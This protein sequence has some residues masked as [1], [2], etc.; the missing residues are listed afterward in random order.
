[1]SPSEGGGGGGNPFLCRVE[2]N[3]MGGTHKDKVLCHEKS[4]YK[5]AYSLVQI[6]MDINPLD[7]GH[8][9]QTHRFITKI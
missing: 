6:K 1:M 8:K 3:G 4:T 5:E 7:T 2:P 9:I